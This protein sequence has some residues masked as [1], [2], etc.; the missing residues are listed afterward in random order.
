MIAAEKLGR[1]A[2]LMEL[3]P[4][5]VDV[6]VLRWQAFTGH[7]AVL[8]DGGAIFAVVAAER[9]AQAPVGAVGA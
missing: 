9:A 3:D 1:Q 5:Y 4:K 2:R 6:I 7:L 8:E